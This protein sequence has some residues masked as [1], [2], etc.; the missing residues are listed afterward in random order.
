[1]FERVNADIT[2]AMKKKEKERLETLR[3]LKSKLLENRT[4]KNPLPE[5][6]VLIAHY[7]KLEESVGAF[8]EGSDQVK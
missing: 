3:Y 2:D 5:M 8:P 6:D 7:Q 1:M 4:S